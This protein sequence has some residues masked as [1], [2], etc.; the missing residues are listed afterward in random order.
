MAQVA[1][2]VIGSV[3]HKVYAITTDAVQD[4]DDW[5]GARLGATGWTGAATLLK[6]QALVTAARYLDRSLWSGDKT[7]SSQPLQWPR[8]GATC[9]GD[10]VTDGTIPDNIAYG[11]F[12]LALALIEDEALQ[13]SSGTGSN[14][15][16]AQ[17]GSAKVEFF[18]PTI[19]LPS[20]DK[21]F[22]QVVHEL[23]AC[24][25]DHDPTLGAPYASGVDPSGTDQASTFCSDDNSYTPTQGYP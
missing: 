20:Q 14:I 4:A 22:P 6:Q 24:Y 7:V 21:R 9:R 18:R 11:Q 3:T 2:I 19:G 10:A 1:D 13:D 16:S 15:K 12:E 17:A 23:V 25:L 5:F 8:D